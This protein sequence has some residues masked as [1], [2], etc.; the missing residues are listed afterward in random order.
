VVRLPSSSVGLLRLPHMAWGVIML[1]G[2]GCIIFTSGVVDAWVTEVSPCRPGAACIPVHAFW[3]AVTF[4][5]R[6]LL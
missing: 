1:L 6:P 3:H 2:L 5:L 4:T